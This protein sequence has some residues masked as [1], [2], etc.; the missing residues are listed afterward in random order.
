[1]EFLNVAF[2]QATVADAGFVY[3]PATGFSQAP[4]SIG[5]VPAGAGT[6]GRG[7]II[8]AAPGQGTLAIMN[9]PAS[10][11][12][13][14]VLVSVSVR[15]TG[16]G[17]SAALAALN[18]PIDGQLGYTISSGTDVPVGQ[19]GRLV[20]LYDA[21]SDALQPGVQVTVPPS[22][23]AGATVYFDNLLVKQLP[24]LDVAAVSLDA[25]GSFDSGTA[26]I[27]QNVNNN[28]GKVDFAG[29][30]GK[31]VLSI[32]SANDAA[33]IGIFASS[34]QAGF[35]CVLE[36]SV[37]AQLLSGSGGVTALVMT[38]GNGN[39]GVL[40][41]N[42]RLPGASASPAAITIGGGFETQNPAF[43]ILCVVQNGGPGVTSAIVIDNLK[44]QR[45]T[46]GL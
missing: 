24:A 26:N 1:V 23:S 3:S 25:D 31:A 45:I 7:L 39:V 15:A 38:N 29:Q 14:S 27:L 9:T 21:P 11:G 43:P 41:N 13:G 19:W 36:A 37:D 34:L 5:N 2:D 18:S 17:C 10:V 42:S 8:D 33:N 30:P 16:S 6:D 12:S 28:T 46:R 22:A 4:I 35:P 32:V 40:V 44:V 20:L